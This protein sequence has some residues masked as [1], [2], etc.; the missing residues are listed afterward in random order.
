MSR[1]Q[2]LILSLELS[3]MAWMGLYLLVRALL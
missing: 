1:L 3:M 2:S